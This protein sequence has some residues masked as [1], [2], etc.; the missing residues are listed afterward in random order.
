MAE[1][2][3]RQRLLKDGLADR[4][5]RELKL[6]N[7]GVRRNPTGVDVQLGNLTIIAVEKGDKVFRQIALI[8]FVQRADNA[9]V[10]ANILRIF[11]VLVADEDVARVHIGMEKLSRNTWVKKTCTPRSASS[12]ILVP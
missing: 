3:L 11:R 1:G 2:D 9:A 7:I 5:D 12:C 10:D 4:A 8:F 6:F